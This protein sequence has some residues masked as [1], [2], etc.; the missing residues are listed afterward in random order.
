MKN[1]ILLTVLV[2]LLFGCTSQ[3]EKKK[4]EEEQHRQQQSAENKRVISNLTTKYNIIYEWDTLHH[5]DY[6]INYKPVIE[7]HYQLIG[8]F[9]ITDV[10]MKDSI[11]YVSLEVLTYPH[12]YFDFSIT[13]E[14]EIKLI[15]G[16]SNR[17]R[18]DLILVVSVNEIRKIKFEL[19]GETDEEIKLD[20][21]LSFIGKGKIIDIVSIKDNF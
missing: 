1:V 13:K 20:H 15:N 9:Y 3:E 12:F 2:S 21:T 16:D 19:T 5:Y 4:K 11:E 6:S 10:Y 17:F 14:Q 7:S 18:N 8:R